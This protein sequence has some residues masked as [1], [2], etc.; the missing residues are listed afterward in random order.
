MKLL[1]YAIRG[2]DAE[3][4]IVSNT[5]AADIL[6]RLVDPT[7]TWL[8]IQSKHPAGPDMTTVIRIADVTRMCTVDKEAE[9]HG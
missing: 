2:D 4:L 6:L 9:D 7:R 8:V 3:T 1:V 5:D